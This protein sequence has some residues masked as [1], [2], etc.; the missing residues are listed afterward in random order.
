MLPTFFE[1]QV[2]RYTKTLDHLLLFLGNP[3]NP[4]GM[5]LL[6]EPHAQPSSK[7]RASVILG[8]KGAGSRFEVL[9]LSEFRAEG[10]GFRVQGSRMWVLG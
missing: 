2:S 3:W 7:R 4:L 1:V 9:G 8:V 10:L 6:R 5:P